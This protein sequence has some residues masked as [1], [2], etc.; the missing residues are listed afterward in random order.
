MSL[1]GESGMIG[2]FILET[3]MI[4]GNG[5]FERTG[6]GFNSRAK[7]SV[8]NAYKYL[9]ANSSNISRNISKTTKDYLIHIQDLNGI[10]ITTEL[11]LPTIIAI[12]SV[13]LKKSQ[14]LCKV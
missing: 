10:G 2:V 13:A 1:G 9:K 12:C 4:F 11:T 8:D 14:Y 3:Q 6:I 5:K 7:E